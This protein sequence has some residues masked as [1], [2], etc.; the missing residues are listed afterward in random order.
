MNKSNSIFSR[1]ELLLSLATRKL[2]ETQEATKDE[3][4]DEIETEA[5]IEV[6]QSSCPLD[7]PGTQDHSRSVEGIL[8]AVVGAN[9]SIELVRQNGSS[10]DE[11]Y[12]DRILFCNSLIPISGNTSCL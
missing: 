12:E 3:F 4:V 10:C 9:A 8:K 11:A 5:N 7:K 1:G 2:T 6:V